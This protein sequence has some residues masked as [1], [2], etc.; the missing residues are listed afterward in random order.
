MKKNNKPGRPTKLI[1]CTK[2]E[3]FKAISEGLSYKDSCIMAGISYRVF[4]SWIEKAK[5]EGA[6]PEYVQFLHALK[7][8]KVE[9]KII[10]IKKI[11]EDPSWQS[12][13]WLLER[14][15]P[16]EFGRLERIEHEE[17]KQ[18]NK[19][20]VEIV[21]TAPPANTHNDS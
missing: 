17:I 2:K 7:K 3:L 12:A 5:G 20:I 14:Q 8:A 4:Y 1:S 21:H 10:N 6:P 15:Y 18:D 16:K 9:G 13:A 11:K 19:M